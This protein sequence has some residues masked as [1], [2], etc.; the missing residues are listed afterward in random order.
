LIEKVPRVFQP[1]VMR[2]C[3]ALASFAG[4]LLSVG[5]EKNA[6]TA[7]PA[8]ATNTPVIPTQYHLN[9]AQPKLRTIKLWIGTQEIDTETA[10]S[11]TEIA[12]GMMF[13]TNMAENTGML[14]P[15]PATDQASFWMKNC[16]LPLSIAYIDP[17][18]VIQEIHDLEPHNTNAVLSASDNIRFALETPQGWFGRHQIHQG[19]VVR[20][21]HGS[22]METFFG[23]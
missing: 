22:L 16:P 11:I 10:V 1:W 4:I 8:A 17:E 9:R 7:A 15:L 13:R 14:F 12:T 20:T 18:G 5:C 21:E 23:K 19:M 2:F 6:A 3:L